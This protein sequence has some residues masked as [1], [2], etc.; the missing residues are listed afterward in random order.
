MILHEVGHAI[1]CLANMKG[2]FL[3]AGFMIR[4]ILPG[5][6]VMIDATDVTKESTDISCRDRGESFIVWSVN[7]FDDIC[8][9]ELISWRVEN[10][11]AICSCAKC[12][13]GTY[14]Y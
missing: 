14:K 5:A 12:N 3:E 11:N 9:R 10:C 4:G 8:T 2:A 13:F 1:A 6:Y 7:D